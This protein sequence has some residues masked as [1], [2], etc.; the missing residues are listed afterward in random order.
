MIPKLAKHYRVLTPDLRGLGDTPVRQNDDYRLRTDVVMVRQWLDA[1]NIPTAD[2]IAH[3]HG[4]AVAQLLMRDDP[5]RIQK[6]VLS[7]V[8]AYD[9]WTSAPKVPILKAIVDPLTSPIMYHALK[10]EW[11]QRQA[12][13]IAVFYEKTL[14][15]EIL[16]GYALPHVATAERWQRLRRFFTWQLNRTHSQTTTVQAVP[17]MRAFQTPTLL[18]WGEKDDNFGPQLARRLARDIPGAQGIHYLHRSEY[19]PFE[20]EPVEY[21]QT[22]LGFLGSGA[23][24]EHAALELAAARTAQK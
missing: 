18:L 6:L 24:T 11:V 4:G 8:E 19:M 10:F 1:L 22:V 3:D 21:A 13:S 17:A 23:V 7:N 15:P 9:Q 16:R 14:T 20:E 12:F 5:T 2:F